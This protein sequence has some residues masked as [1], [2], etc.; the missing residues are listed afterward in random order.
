MKT[1]LRLVF[2]AIALFFVGTAGAS[3]SHPCHDDAYR[4]C[5]NVIPDHAKIQHCLERNMYHLHPACRAQFGK[6]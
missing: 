2:A 6:R 5:R 3:A 4:F 1:N